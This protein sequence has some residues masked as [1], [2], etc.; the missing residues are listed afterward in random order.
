[1]RKAYELYFGCKVRNRDES[2]APKIC[3]SSCSRSLAGWWKVTHKSMPFAVLMVWHEPQDHL[4]HNYFCA[5]KITGFSQFF[6]HESILI[7]PMSLRSVS[8][9]SMPV[10]KPSTQIYKQ[11]RCHQMIQDPAKMQT[12]IFQHSNI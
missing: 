5:T 4:Y 7:H 11:K 10:P 9:D 6:K 1:M 12:R 8:H 3:S 2:W